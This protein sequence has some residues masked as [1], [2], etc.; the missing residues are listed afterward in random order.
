MTDDPTPRTW[1]ITMGGKTVSFDD[2][3]TELF[4]KVAND[5]GESW[6]SL[7][8]LPIR[9]SYAYMELVGAIAAYL[10]V[11][12]PAAPT[13]MGGLRKLTE[14]LEQ[15]PVEDGV[16]EVPVVEDEPEEESADV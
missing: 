7:Y 11:E 2:L 3:P 10:E 8:H 13:T 6:V 4:Q 16:T 12:P 14:L 15:V 5:T 9:N 1:Q